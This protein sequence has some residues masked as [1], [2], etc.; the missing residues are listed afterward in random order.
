MCS[1]VSKY[2][3]LICVFLQFLIRFTGTGNIMANKS[4]QI[5]KLV[6]YQR[7]F[8]NETLYWKPG[9]NKPR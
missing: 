1:N 2:H 8:S 4:L 3:D 6:I 9:A 5:W 7:I